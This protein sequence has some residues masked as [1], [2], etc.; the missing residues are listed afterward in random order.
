MR[1]L[2]CLLWSVVRSVGG[3]GPALGRDQV[4][5]PPDLPLDELEAVALQLGGVAVARTPVRGALA[6]PSQPLLEPGATALED[7]ESDL[8]VDAPE[9]READVE[10]LVLPR[11]G[12]GRSEEHT[13]ELQSRQY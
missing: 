4:G 3:C 10:G 1:V 9:E 12:A 7:A 11:S 8:A 6:Q 5:E 2:S 13:S